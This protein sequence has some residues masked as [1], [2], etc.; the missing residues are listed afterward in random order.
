MACCVWEFTLAC[1]LNCIHCGSSAGRKRDDELTTEEALRLCADLK[2]TGCLG[3]ALMGGEPFLRKDFWQVAQKIRD[4]GMELSVITNG[5]IVDEEI[6]KK[7]APL[8]PRAVAV[9]IDA[10]S[11]ELHDKIRGVPGSFDKSRAF[12]NRCLR[13][14]LPVSVITTVHKLNLK[15]L[16]AIREQLKGRKIAWQVQTAGAEGCRF[17]KELLLDDEEFYSVGVFIEVSRRT[18]PAGEL[19]LIGAH[20]LGYNSGI[21]KNI[22]LYGKWEGCQAGVSVLGVRSNGDILGCLAINDDRFLEGNVRKRNVYGL[23]NDPA[24]FSY[25]RNFNKARA[26]A[27]C[28]TCGYLEACKGGCN[29]MSL[30]KTGVMHNDP[31]CFYRLEHK[32]FAEELRNPFKRLWFRLNGL[33]NAGG[34]AFGKLGGIFG[35]KR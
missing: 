23:W 10:A 19:P 31:C 34:G 9:S 29:E 26:G 4:L 12:I 2:K 35:G 13:E 1:N 6:I 28:L 15:E 3:V 8:A 25:T 16:A 30:T 21:L 5:A 11:A 33:A 24:A 7:L 14:G 20:D 32:L 22:S 27:N 18:Q 17:P